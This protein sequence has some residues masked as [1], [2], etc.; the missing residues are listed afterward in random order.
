M[1]KWN[2]ADLDLNGTAEQNF[3]QIEDKVRE[4]NARLRYVFA[5]IDKEQN[6]EDK[7]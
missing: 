4:I 6:T 1:A 2:V 5:Q 7:A 3:K